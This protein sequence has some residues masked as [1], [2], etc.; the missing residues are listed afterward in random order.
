MVKYILVLIA[1]LLI[2]AGCTS[3][4]E[5]NKIALLFLDSKQSL[6][7]TEL[8]FLNKITNNYDHRRL[9]KNKLEDKS[10]F[11][12]YDIKNTPTIILFEDDIELLRYESRS[13]IEWYWVLKYE[14]EL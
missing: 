13:K 10:F 8:N 6:S 7:A 5:S 12:K 1:M 2:T 4:K 3:T 9:D 14:V 11:I